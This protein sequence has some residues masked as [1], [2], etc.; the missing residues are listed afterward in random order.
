MFDKMILI[1]LLV[2]LVILIVSIKERNQHFH[3][4]HEIKINNQS[5]LYRSI[6]NVDEKIKQ[7]ESIIES[8][9]QDVPKADVELIENIIEEWAEIQKSH[10]RDDRSWVRNKSKL[11]K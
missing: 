8:H 5:R 3:K 4:E 6:D 7:L 10:H 1:I 2:F 9:M 11:D